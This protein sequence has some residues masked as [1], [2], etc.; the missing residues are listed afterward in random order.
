MR[1]TSIVTVVL[2]LAA[3]TAAADPSAHTDAATAKVAKDGTDRA[4]LVASKAT[5]AKRYETEL[6][7]VD[8]LKHQRKSWRRER[9]LQD[10]QAKALDTAKELSKLS[11]RITGLDT[12]IATDKHGVVVAIDAE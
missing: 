2:A 4:A 9:Q 7:A 10:A 5:V 1:R 3:S 8:H 11:A 6:A 12:A